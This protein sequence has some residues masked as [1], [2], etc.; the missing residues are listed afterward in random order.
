MDSFIDFTSKSFAIM[1]AAGEEAAPTEIDPS[2][3]E[4]SEPDSDEASTVPGL[5]PIPGEAS[6]AGPGEASEAG[7][8]M[9]SGMAPEAG[10]EMAS[11]AGHEMAS[12]MAPEIIEVEDSS[13][14]RFPVPIVPKLLLL[15]P[16]GPAAAYLKKSKRG[17]AKLSPNFKKIKK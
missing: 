16:S 10:P 2:S 4:P 15:V 9:A 12:E 7:P 6:E 5:N 11:E 3:P 17:V 13:T 14:G 1:S 8:E